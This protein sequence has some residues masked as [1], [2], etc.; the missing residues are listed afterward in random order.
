MKDRGKSDEQVD[1]PP[2][3]GGRLVVAVTVAM[4]LGVAWGRGR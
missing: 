1:A 4:L 2:H 3:D